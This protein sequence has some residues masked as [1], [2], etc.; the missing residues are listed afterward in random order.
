MQQQQLA[1][2]LQVANLSSSTMHG[3]QW[4]HQ[5]AS[6]KQQLHKLPGHLG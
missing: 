3:P 5:P 4:Q 6:R 1:G 2:M